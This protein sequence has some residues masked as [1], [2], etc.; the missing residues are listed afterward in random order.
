MLLELSGGFAV[1]SNNRPAANLTSVPIY[2]LP[3]S[4]LGGWE[5][6]FSSSTVKLGF[7]L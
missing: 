5:M 3:K 2:F 1:R 7:S 4:T 6:A